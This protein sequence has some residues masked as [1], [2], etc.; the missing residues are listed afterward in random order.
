MQAQGTGGRG[1]L[2]GRGAGLLGRGGGAGLLGGRGAGL[3]SGRGGGGGGLRA[4]VMGGAKRG[5]R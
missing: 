4:R 5:F 1:L 2:A 3:L